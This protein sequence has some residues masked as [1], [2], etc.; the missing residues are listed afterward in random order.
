MQTIMCL[1]KKVGTLLRAIEKTEQ[2][3]SYNIFVFYI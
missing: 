1:A 2:N 3:N